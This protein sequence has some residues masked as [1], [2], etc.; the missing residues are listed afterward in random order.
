MVIDIIVTIVAGVFLAVAVF[1]TMYPVLPGSPVAFVTLIAWGWV[2][3]SAASWTAAGI[4]ALLACVGFLA[5]AL[6]T[7][8]RLKKEQIP[9]R[10]ILVA[11]L[12]GIVGMFVIPVAGLFVGFAAGLFVSEYVR[13]GDFQ[14]ALRSSGEALKAMGLGMLVEFGM[15]ALAS[16]VWMIGVIVH[17]AV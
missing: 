8:R 5:S 9:R 4:G 1:G 12:A 17:F 7:G 10:S 14:S 15:V 3:G 13:R 2:L 11:V 6:L 16:S